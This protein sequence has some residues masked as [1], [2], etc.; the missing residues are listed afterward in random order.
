MIE[1]KDNVDASITI[2][3]KN[4][5]GRFKEIMNAIYNQ[6]FDGNVEIVVVDS[7]STD[8]TIN[9]AREY[10]ARIFSIKPQEFHHSLTRN[11]GAER[12]RGKV[13]IYLSQDALPLNSSW[14]S[15]LLA[16]LERSD[17]AAVYGRQIAYPN[18]KPVDAFFY[19]Y[20]YPDTK[21][22]LTK[23]DTV[24]LRKFYLDNIFISDV[25]SAIKRDAWE[26]LKFRDEIFM[27]E[28][29]DFA[30]RVLKTGYKI[31]YEP[32]AVVYHSHDYTLVSLFRRR[33]KDGVAYSY[34][35]P[36]GSDKFVSNGMKYFLEEVK[37]LTKRY[38]KWLPYA[39]I[40]DF[41][42]FLA[43]QLGKTYGR[44]YQQ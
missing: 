18:A 13:L 27:S 34:I 37:F 1:S 4:A 22:I 30:L 17:V 19:S 39:L 32:K 21:K 29:K 7:G 40:Y 43:F 2:L 12:S 36:Y 10:N 5:G 14:L 33:F 6:K 23:E 42:H 35:A 31:V 16:P 3:T 11:F 44:S 24:D 38:P 41:T 15:N 20:F 25:C 9:I 8:N 26:I 28:D